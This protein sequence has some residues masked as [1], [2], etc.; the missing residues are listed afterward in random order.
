MN[1]YYIIRTFENDAIPDQIIKTGL[2][3]EQARAH[4]KDPETSYSTATSLDAVLRTKNFGVWF[5]GY[6]EHKPKESNNP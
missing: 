1:N 3:L 2:T 5:D 4:C 6:E